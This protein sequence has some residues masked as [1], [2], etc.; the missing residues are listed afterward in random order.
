MILFVHKVASWFLKRRM[1]HV[2]EF[3]ENPVGVQEALFRQLITKA[4][5]TDWGR[6][7]DYASINHIDDYRQRV[8]IS[9]YEALYPWFERCIKGEKDVLWPGRISW[10]SKSSGTTNDKSKYI[11]VTPE[12]LD[13]CHYA[14]GQDMLALYLQHKEDSR[15]F[16]GKTL[17]IG[18][19]HNIHEL[20]VGARCGDV[21]AVLLENLPRFYELVRTPSKEVAL[22]DKWEQKIDAMAREVMEEDVTSMVGVPTWT[23][24][25]INKIFEIT[26]NTDRNLLDIWP[27]LE[28]Y[29]HGGVSF[30]PYRKE[31]QRIIPS[32]RM[33]YLNC[34]NASEGFFAVQDHPD[35]PGML[36]M[37]D[38]GVFFEFLPMEHYGEEFPATHTIGEVETGRNY[39]VV[40]ST[41]AGLWR[42]LIGD[43]VMF[44][45]TQPHRINVTG[46]TKH[47]INAF[48][49]ELMVDN[50]ERAIAAASEATGAQVDNYSAAPIY[51]EGS[52]K[53]GHEWVVEF[54]QAPDNL[55]NFVE[56]LDQTLRRLNSDYAAK[57][58]GKWL[59]SCLP[60][61][62]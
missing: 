39:A 37:L 12:A 30:E 9:N 32:D 20:N 44:T 17:S 61:T 14:A 54:V 13:V 4:R 53:G 50:A 34:Y 25:L 60:A 49:E 41:N 3:R 33:T 46:R 51:F 55:D 42:Y 21:S 24:V 26:G 27:N 48:G 11:P 40:I 22:M 16:A 23:M 45:H 7:Y 18:G 57:R 59:L 2:M 10:F 31:F 52:S 62:C 28:L 1:E 35:I 19:S 8:P 15:L 43:T 29:V 36:L 38:Y 58:E 56:V 6:T 47:F 5:D